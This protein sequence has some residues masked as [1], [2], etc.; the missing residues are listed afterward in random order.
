MQNQKNIWMKLSS[1]IARPVVAITCICFLLIINAM[2]IFVLNS[3]VN[4]NPANSLAQGNELRVA[5]EY[6]QL[7]STLYEYE[8]TMQ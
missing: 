6:N 1:F 4:S 5:D 8:N 2:V 3:S 7:N